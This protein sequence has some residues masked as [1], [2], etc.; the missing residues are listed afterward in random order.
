MEQR[1]FL[2]T[3]ERSGAC[4]RLWVR[5]RPML[6]AEA[7]VF[8]TADEA[9][10]N[11]IS[12]ATGDGE[13]VREY[14]PPRPRGG[15]S[16]L[17]FRLALISGERRG[18]IENPAELFNGGYCPQCKYPRGNR[19][20]SPLRLARLEPGRN[21]GYAKLEP[22]ASAGP[23]MD[24]FSEPF[25]ACL[26][27]EERSQFQW[28]PVQMPSKTRERF[29]EL[30]RANV[31]V[32]FVSLSDLAATLWN[33]PSVADRG[34]HTLW[35]CDTCGRTQQPLYWYRMASLPSFYLNVADLPEPLPSCIGVGDPEYP[36]LCFTA[37]RWSELVKLEVTHGLVS[38]EVGVVAQGL[39]DPM[40]AVRSLGELSKENR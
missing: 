24:F 25:V 33:Q 2:C 34:K 37:E 4:Y 16:G 7:D 5:D 15:R 13:S 8:E 17:L 27:P 35:R 21:G 31:Q 6:V 30:V 11:A 32:P 40:P 20:V 39:V 22:P 14:D 28:R 12:G 1:L 19:T 29:V 36:S 10:A 3:W 38:T 9:L 26:R 18:F 23:L